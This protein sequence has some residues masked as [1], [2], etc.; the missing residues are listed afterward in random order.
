MIWP[1]R[2]D[3]DLVIE[4]YIDP[5]SG[6]ACRRRADWDREAAVLR[7]AAEGRRSSTSLAVTE[8]DESDLRG[9]RGGWFRG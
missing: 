6:P 5:P 1:S 3:A 2:A 4:G 9:D 7:P 8:R